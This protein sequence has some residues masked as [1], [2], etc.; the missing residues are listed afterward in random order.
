MLRKDSFL[1]GDALQPSRDDDVSRRIGIHKGC[2][3]R[4]PTQTY[5]AKVTI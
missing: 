4:S 2:R 3:S 1:R 5:A